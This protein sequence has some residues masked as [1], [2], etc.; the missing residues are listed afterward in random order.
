MAYVAWTPQAGAPWFTPLGCYMDS[1]GNGVV[2][3]FDYL[4]IKLNWTRVHGAINPKQS[5]GMAVTGFD[6]SQNYPNPFNP[7]TSI[8][9]NIPERS[10][11]TLRVTDMLGRVVETLVQGS[12]E[13]GAHVLSF[14]GGSLPSGQYNATVS[15]TG[16]ES[17]LSYTRT[18]RMLL[19]K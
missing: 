16:R 5:D 18:I 10:E 11:V 7:A 1:D 9:L 6:M 8:R 19:S 3:N 4:A 14:D 17:G 13:A 15:M 2:N 12:M